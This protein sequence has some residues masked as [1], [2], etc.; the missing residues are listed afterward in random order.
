MVT[1]TRATLDNTFPVFIR[2]VL[3]NYLTDPQ[4]P[5]R[6]A[7]Q[8]IF[9]EEPEDTDFE[10]AIVVVML[11]K[12]SADTFNIEGT[13]AKSPVASVKIDI[14]TRK[15]EDRDNLI[16]EIKAALL[17]IASTD[18]TTSI[19][20]NYLFPNKHEITIMTPTVYKFPKL[21]RE[22]IVSIDYTYIGA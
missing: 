9:K 5:A 7:N 18:G 10:T 12:D 19:R 21:L 8:W 2:D 6:P 13:K 17:N 1:I 22:G 20:G 11:N 3:R 15:L 14:W 16:S 4:V